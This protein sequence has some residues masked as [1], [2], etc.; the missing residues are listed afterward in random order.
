MVHCFSVLIVTV[1]FVSLFIHRV[2]LQAMLPKSDLRM[3]SIKKLVIL[4]GGG[5]TGASGSTSELTVSS[6][7]VGFSALLPSTAILVHS[8]ILP[9]LSI[10]VGCSLFAR[11]FISQPV[12]TRLSIS[13]IWAWINMTSLYLFDQWTSRRQN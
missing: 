12:F 4:T 10:F 6:V 13:I 1:D 7:D 2:L 3:S 9:S 5:S 8:M 11:F